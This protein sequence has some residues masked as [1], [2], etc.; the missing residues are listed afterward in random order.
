MQ[1]TNLD[2]SYFCLFFSP[3]VKE[4]RFRTGDTIQL[5]EGSSNML[6]GEKTGREEGEEGRQRKQLCLFLNLVT[7][8]MVGLSAPTQDHSWGQMKADLG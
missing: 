2:V 8:T 6:W 5:V 3:G 1:T 7:D 4:Q